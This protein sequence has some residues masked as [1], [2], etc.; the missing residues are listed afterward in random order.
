MLSQRRYFT[1]SNVSNT[2]IKGN[3]KGDF[4]NGWFTFRFPKQF[5]ESSNF[6]KKFRIISFTYV[7]ETISTVIDPISG[8]PITSSSINTDV[9]ITMHGDFNQETNELDRFMALSNYGSANEKTFSVP[10]Q[11]GECHVW[12]RDWDGTTLYPALTKDVFY[13]QMELFY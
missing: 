1:I 9:G 3:A 7:R 8:D 6:E 4:A 10:Y 11:L 13:I 5:E 2:T 12:F